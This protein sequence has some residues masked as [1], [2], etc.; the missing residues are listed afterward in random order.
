M[1]NIIDNF[2]QVEACGSFSLFINRPVF[3]IYKTTRGYIKNTKTGANMGQIVELHMN[4]YDEN[5]N[6]LAVVT[7]EEDCYEIVE[8]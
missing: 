5:H 8:D 1:A 6:K 4:L 3:K 2:V 7:C